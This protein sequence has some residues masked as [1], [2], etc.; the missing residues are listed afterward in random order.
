MSGKAKKGGLSSVDDLTPRRNL[1]SRSVIPEWQSYG[2]GAPAP[3]SVP[4]P[5]PKVKKYATGGGP[6][7]APAPRMPAPPMPRP[8]PSMLSRAA[9]GVGGVA[10]RVAGPVGNVLSLNDLYNFVKDAYD[11]ARQYEQGG[12]GDLP[13]SPL[14][15]GGKVSKVMREYKA[16]ELHSGSKRGPVVKNPKQAIAIALSEARRAGAKIPKKAA[17]GQMTP[18]ERRALDRMRHAE[19]YAPGLSLDMPGKRVKKK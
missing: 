9:S 18:Q 5:A 7:S 19:R 16:G 6:A 14:K 11:N 3:K 12:Y 15:R 13:A 8:S 10:K 17:G 4:K 2:Y 1:P